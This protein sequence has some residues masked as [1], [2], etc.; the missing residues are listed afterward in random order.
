VA[1]LE[2]SWIGADSTDLIAIDSHARTLRAGLGALAGHP[3]PAPTCP[4]FIH[5]HATGTAHDAYELA[6]IR[7]IF[8][9]SVPVFSHKKWLG[10]S[11]GAA[12]LVSV[13]ISALC[14]RH[15]RM[16]HGDTVPP[17]ARSITIAQGF[18]GHVGVVALRG[19]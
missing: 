12:G 15:R 9:A 19:P 6:A 18:G 2:D 10:H 14:H 5:A 4:S 11:L 3:P 16:P 13:V 1:W 17:A 7:S 8:G